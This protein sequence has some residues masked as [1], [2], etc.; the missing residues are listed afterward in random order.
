MLYSRR[1]GDYKYHTC[2]ST[3]ADCDKYFTRFGVK[4]A[5]MYANWHYAACKVMNT[6][7]GKVCAAADRSFDGPD[8]WGIEFCDTRVPLVAAMIK[9]DMMKARQECQEYMCDIAKKGSWKMFG[10]KKAIDE[11]WP[12]EIPLSWDTGFINTAHGAGE[13]FNSIKT[14]FGGGCFSQAWQGRT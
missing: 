10:K 9:R 14:T 2:E 12:D 5:N 1:M 13:C 8:D 3:L 7:K 6:E 4:F 11:P